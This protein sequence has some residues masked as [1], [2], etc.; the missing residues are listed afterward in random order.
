MGSAGVGKSR[1]VHELLQQVG[2]EGQVLRT[3]CLP[4]GEG[5]TFWPI[6]EL[7]QAAAGIGPADG[8]ETARGKLETLLE[9]ADERDAIVE[10]VAAAIGLSAAVVPTEEIFWGVRKLLEAIARRQPLIVVMD[11]V[12]WAEPTMLDLI[13]HV[14][15]WS[16]EA[17]IL[18][19][20]IARPEMLDARPHWG[21]GKMNATTILLEPLCAEDSAELVGNLINDRTLAQ[22]VQGRIG[23]TAE[24]NPLFVEELVA[25][26]VDEGVLRR[27]NGGWQADSD[28]TQVSVPPTVSALVAARLD[29]LEPSERDLIGRASVVGKVFQ[30]SAVTELSPPER[31]EDLGAQLMLL[32]RKELVRPDR[33]STIGDEAFRFRHILVRDAAYGSLPKEQRADLHAR[34][35]AWLEAIAGERQLEY[36]EVIAYHLEQAHRYR[37]E[38]GLTDELT[39]SLAA[40]AAAHLRSAGLRALGRHDPPA[41]T[42]L[43]SRAV[44]LLDDDRQRGEIL[45]HLG[46]AAIDVGDFERATVLYDQ[47][48]AAAQL[49]NDELLEMR[50]ELERMEWQSLIDPSADDSKMLSLADR[51]EA[52]AVEL[53]EKSGTIAAGFARAAAYLMQ[54]RWMDQLTALE[55]VREL[56]D[57]REDPRQWL[58]CTLMTCNALRWGPV[59]AAEAIER[60]EATNWGDESHGA[61]RLGFSAP[62]LAMLG[63]SD[64]ARGR[65]LAA[66]DYL[67]ERGLRMRVGDSALHR[68]TVEDLAG[69]LEA[70]DRVL[71]EGIAILQ[72]IGETG[73][74]STL[75]AMRASV[76]YRLGRREEME[77]AVLLAQEAGASNDIATQVYWRVAAAQLGA[78]DGRHDDAQRHM[79]EALE[80]MKPTDFLELRGSAFEALAHVE[81][82]AG[83]PD[84]WRVALERALAE[85]DRKG[86]LVSA[87]RIRDQLAAGPPDP[88]SAA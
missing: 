4:Y 38:L 33:S 13:E 18:L 78:D 63:R 29:R 49:A 48:K 35:A 87:G 25:M 41:A 76:L 32:V 17:P 74:L 26:L 82:R 1:L 83:H 30:R 59:H 3:R 14:S 68:S 80:L 28:L 69:D 7:A 73:V 65:S 8:A 20:A 19:L 27:V 62:L 67:E 45:M 22:A 70:A 60:I 9:G 21:G 77:A 79:N 54:C 53:G 86:N 71:G 88:V 57:P 56:L 75:A 61:G 31:R 23:E 15:D 84:G 16:H 58:R 36:E 81:A 47:V 50:A 43:L 6:V 5:I 85:H 10:R 40:N 55:R 72:S 51:V 46:A 66:H 11:D 44:A 34:F 64:E 24:G 42:N 2:G 39:R 37:A 52:R 12:H